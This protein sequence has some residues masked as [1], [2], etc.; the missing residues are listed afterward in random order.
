VKK[1]IIIKNKFERKMKKLLLCT[2]SMCPL[3]ASAVNTS[4]AGGVAPNGGYII[5]VEQDMEPHETRPNGYYKAFMFTGGVIPY[6]ENAVTFRNHN[7]VVVTESQYGFGVGV[8]RLFEI[9][10]R[11]SFKLKTNVGLAIVYSAYDYEFSACHAY[12]YGS[13]RSLSLMQEYG[14]ALQLGEN[15]DLRAE[16]LAVGFYAPLASV[17]VKVTL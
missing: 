9:I 12:A 16:V 10:S 17:G 13:D 15:V 6:S 4:I 2:L 11:P 14:L 1:I 8:Y 5:S 3:L 7:D